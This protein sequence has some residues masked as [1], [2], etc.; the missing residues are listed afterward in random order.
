[1]YVSYIHPLPFGM[2]VPLVTE[3]FYRV[4]GRLFQQNLTFDHLF[5]KSE[6]KEN[7]S[8]RS[9]VDNFNLHRKRSFID[10]QTDHSPT[11][12]RFTEILQNDHVTCRVIKIIC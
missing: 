3:K 2:T 7:H 1:M 5:S 12:R 9:K 4:K 10:Q 6:I 11:I 8:K